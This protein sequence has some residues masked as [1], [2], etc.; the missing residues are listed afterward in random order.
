MSKLENQPPQSP[1]VLAEKFK[2]PD[3]TAKGEM[4]AFVPLSSLETLWINTG[5]LCNIE[6]VNC[7]IESSPTNDRLSYISASETAA[8]LDEIE[9][10]KLGTREVAFTGGEPFMNPDMIAML[11]DALRRGFDALVLTNAMKPLQRK[12]IKNALLD[13]RDR[14]GDKLTLRIS[15]DH[16]T[17]EL[18]DRERG[19]GSFDKALV[20]IDWLSKNDFNLN[21]AG[22]TIW[23]ED[24]AQG[25]KGYGD[26]VKS[27]Q[28][29]I[30]IDDPRQ[31]ILF[32]E[33]DAKKDVPEITTK[34]WELLNIRPDSMMCASSR[35]V[36]KRR[37]AKT[38][39]LV[40]CTLIAYE[41]RF[42]MGITLKEAAN[43]DGG[44]FADGAV[45]LCHPYCAKFCVLGGG[46]CSA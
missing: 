1:P 46:S 34:C 2:D 39:Q 42:E 25:R 22:R 44:M 38:P 37:G 30:E 11:E 21:L 3:W 41:E 10:Q 8:Y 23:N 24:E 33:M 36:I 28:W 27:Q 12:K 9:Q 31:L 29:S 18:H 14:F 45:K 7:Y 40:P 15:L 4:R 5:T 43:A 17:H 19:Q 13:L 35:M 16:Y 32:P 6:C 20:G 26:L